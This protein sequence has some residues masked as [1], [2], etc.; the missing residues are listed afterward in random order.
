[1]VP[2]YGCFNYF[3]VT[4]NFDATFNTNENIFHKLKLLL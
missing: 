2:S 3:C 1:L 4:L